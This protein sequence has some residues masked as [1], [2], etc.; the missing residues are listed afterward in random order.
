MGT[1][2]GKKAV[3]VLSLVVHASLSKY[4]LSTADDAASVH[5]TDTVYRTPYATQ[6]AKRSDPRLD[7]IE[8]GGT[9]SQPDD[10][11]LGIVEID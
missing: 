2:N 8:S 3:F 10:I 11:S 4:E 7:P 6:G 5:L 1:S 9:E